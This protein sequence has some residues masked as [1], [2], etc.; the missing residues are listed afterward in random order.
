M[1]IIKCLSCKER[2]EVENL[3]EDLMKKETCFYCGSK[4]KDNYALLEGD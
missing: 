4:L 2:V 1:E 3:F